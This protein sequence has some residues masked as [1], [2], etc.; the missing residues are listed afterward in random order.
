[1]ALTLYNTLTREKEA[2]EP[3]EEGRVR[4]YT[5]GPTVYDRAHI[6]NFRTFAWEDLLRRYL[7]WKGYDVVQ[8]MNLTDVDDKTIA[9]S[10]ARGVSLSEVTDPVVEAFFEDWDTL[11]LQRVEH[12]PRATECVAEMIDLVRRLEEKGYTYRAD[13]SVYFDISAFEAYGELANLD[14]DDLEETGR[15]RSDE[16]YSK[17]DPR[18]FVLWKGG[19]R[20]EEGDVATWDS[21]WGPGRPGWHLEC[22]TMAMKHL[23]E[24]LDIHTGGVDNIFPHHENEIAQS[25]G[26]TGRRFVR[27]WLHAAHLLV[28]GGKMSKSLGNFYTVPDLLE[29]GARP[30]AVRYLLL[31][32]HY[33]TQLNFTLEGVEDADR[34]LGRIME[35]R[36]RLRDARASAGRE[37]G[38]S[39]GRDPLALEADGASEAFERAMDDDL[40][41]S[42]ALAAVFGLVR[43]GN[44][45]L[46]EDRGGSEGV[47]RALAFLED[48]DAVFGVLSLR[49]GERELPEEVQRWLEARIAERE[50]A[51]EAG[52]YERADAIRD[53]VESRGIVLE[54]TPDGVRWKLRDG[55]PD[56]IVAASGEAAPGA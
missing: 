19:D 18:D 44:A 6:G 11:G 41:V 52:D 29:R 49:E 40:N 21:P 30:S 2:F 45:L 47:R 23:G 20:P 3:L 50:A 32:A 15:A 43:K 8:V 42:D 22:S 13:G 14:P 34:A 46:D 39:T 1:M 55:S 27:T 56:A 36:G 35:F 28:D 7:D 54:D 25:E 12:V 38:S 51:R 4:M 37:N 16:E 17:E 5:C 31:S 33:R 26:A 53:E 10:V 24:T 48:F 9:A